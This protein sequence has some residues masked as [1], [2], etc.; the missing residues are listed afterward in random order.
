VLLE[1]GGTT[2]FF[3]PDNVVDLTADQRDFRKLETILPPAPLALAELE[4]EQLSRA[5]QE[6]DRIFLREQWAE[7]SDVLLRHAHL[8]A[9]FDHRFRRMLHAI[10]TADQ[11]ALDGVLQELRATYGEQIV[12]HLYSG[13]CNEHGIPNRASPPA[14]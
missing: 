12:F 2:E 1:P 8:G 4:I 3:S 13:Y 11:A 7:A 6:F 9:A 5:V 10:H 14:R